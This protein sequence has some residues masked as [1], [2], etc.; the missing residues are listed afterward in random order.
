MSFTKMIKT[1]G[2]VGLEEGT[3]LGGKLKSSFLP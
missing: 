3:D 1:G 2:E